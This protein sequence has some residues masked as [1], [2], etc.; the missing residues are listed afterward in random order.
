MTPSSVHT[1]ICDRFLLRGKVQ[2]RLG[3]VS[4][5][6]RKPDLKKEPLV[7][8]LTIVKIYGYLLIMSVKDTL[9]LHSDRL[10]QIRNIETRLS[11]YAIPLTP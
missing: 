5:L 2:S 8:G 4:I 11:P 3:P 9:R 1:K 6:S 10:C 7:F